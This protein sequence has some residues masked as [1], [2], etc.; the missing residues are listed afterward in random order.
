MKKTILNSIP[1]TV[2]WLVIWIQ[3]RNI[4][5]KHSKTEKIGTINNKTLL[6]WTLAKRFTT[7]ILE[8][9]RAKIFNHLRFITPVMA[10]TSFGKS[11]VTLKKNV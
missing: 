7:V 6:L 3:K 9:P 2:S 5:M 1:V 8:P 4:A 10:S 11:F